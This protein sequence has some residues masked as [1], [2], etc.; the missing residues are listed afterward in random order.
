MIGYAGGDPLRI[1]EASR[2]TF[3]EACVYYGYMKQYKNEN[4]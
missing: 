2:K 4:T 3:T 1:E